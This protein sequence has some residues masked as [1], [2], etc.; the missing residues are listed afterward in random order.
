MA[1]GEN[2]D[3]FFYLGFFYFLFLNG[4]MLVFLGLGKLRFG[5][6]GC[7]AT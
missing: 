7:L 5:F 3:F 2:V 1:D 4:L 6:L